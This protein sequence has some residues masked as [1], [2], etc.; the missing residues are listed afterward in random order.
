MSDQEFLESDSDLEE[1]LSEE[2]NIVLERQ[3]FIEEG[4][5]CAKVIAWFPVEREY[6]LCKFLIRPDTKIWG[7][8][9]IPEVGELFIYQR[10]RSISTQ[11][12]FPLDSIQSAIE[13]L[14]QKTFEARKVIVDLI[15]S[16]K[17]AERNLPNF[18]LLVMSLPS[19]NEGQEL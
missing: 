8:Y 2:N 6:N 14:D 12:V 7:H 18:K 1:L 3:I 11:K 19:S 13:W 5:L 15:T 16:Y 9:M 10:A 4:V 17:E